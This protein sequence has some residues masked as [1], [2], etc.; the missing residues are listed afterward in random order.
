MSYLVL[1]EFNVRAQLHGLDLLPM[2]FQ[3]DVFKQKIDLPSSEEHVFI[4]PTD[5]AAFDRYF[6]EILVPVLIKLIHLDPVLTKISARQRKKD[7]DDPKGYFHGSLVEDKLKEFKLLCNS[8][9]I[10]PKGWLQWNFYSSPRPEGSR[11]LPYLKWIVHKIHCYANPGTIPKHLRK[12]GSST[13]VAFQAPESFREY[14]EIKVPDDSDDPGPIPS[15]TE[16]ATAP[17]PAPDPQLLAENEKL[18]E[19]LQKARAALAEERNAHK[20]ALEA[21]RQEYDRRYNESWQWEIS[22]GRALDPFKHPP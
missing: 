10:K 12:D 18:K 22:Q 2:P 14:V 19:E 6:D 5:Q 3:Y 17:E 21:E 15:S 4:A 16:V 11:R 20:V 9:S 13:E 1:S 7:R 8:P